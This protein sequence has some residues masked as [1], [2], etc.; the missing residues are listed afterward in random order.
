LSKG[1]SRT[2][3]AEFTYIRPA[4]DQLIL[5]GEMDD[6]TIRVRLKLV[7]LDTFRLLNSR[8]RWVRPPDPFAG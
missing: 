1:S 3:R 2:W 5:A 7:P 6:R 4:D 8:F